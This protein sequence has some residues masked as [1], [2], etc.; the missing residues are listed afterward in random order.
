MSP[1][2]IAEAIIAKTKASAEAAF[3]E[4]LLGSTAYECGALGEELRSAL[5]AMAE[6]PKAVAAYLKR[7][8][9]P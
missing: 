9:A 8:S 7:I 6:G 4:S 5:E 2:E 3:P 1:R